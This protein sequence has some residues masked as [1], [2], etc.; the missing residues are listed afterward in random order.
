M[1]ANRAK[2]AL[3]AGEK[4]ANER[5]MAAIKIAPEIA[6]LINISEDKRSEFCDQLVNILYGTSVTW[7]LSKIAKAEDEVLR[8]DPGSS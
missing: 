1:S 4:W 7:A 5:D 6:D 2:A 3:L 8:A